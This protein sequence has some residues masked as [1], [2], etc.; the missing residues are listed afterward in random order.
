MDYIDELRGKSI[1]KDI[2]KLS[3]DYVPKELPHREEE[4]KKLARIFRTILTSNMTQ[5]V[6]ITGKVGTGKTVISKH[7][8]S[9]FCKFALKNNK[10]VDYI[11]IN[12]RKRSTESMVM[13]KI[14]SH[15]QKG[16]PDRGFSVG[17]MFEILAKNIEKR[18]THLIII[19]DEVDSLIKRS[20]SDLIYTFT[21][22]SE[23]EE[24][25]KLP[26]SLILISQ[27]YVLDMLD[28]ASISTFGRSNIIE[29]G[30]Y[31]RE[32]LCNILKQ[33]VELAFRSNSVDEEI[34][35]LIADIASEWGDARFAIEILLKSGMIADE[36]RKENIEAEDVRTAKASIYSVVTEEK[37]K[38]L[39]KQKKLVLVAIARALKN[40]AFATTGEIENA[41]F[42]VCEEH[43]EKKR[44][45]TQFWNYL[46]DLDNFGIIE[47]KKGAKGIVGTTT[48]VSLPD[49]PAK[50]LEEKVSSLLEEN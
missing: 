46:K 50:V 4:L 45:H 35:E 38:D 27:K 29:L 14:M 15:F 12:C 40:K 32:E 28:Q 16:F 43:N 25:K 37:L 11:F 7:F 39:D 23:E 6:L 21:R 8:C 20:G 22:F 24:Y 44:G 33:R 31:N 42:V 36:E 3:F 19:L 10:N 48:L 30:K 2:D 18:K 34:I 17:E 9:N 49:I 5:N 47:A 13:L 41:Y 1:F 26:I